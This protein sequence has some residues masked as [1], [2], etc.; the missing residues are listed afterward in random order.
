MLVKYTNEL[1]ALKPANPASKT[2]D[3]NRGKP[4]RQINRFQGK[5]QVQSWKAFR[6]PGFVECCVIVPAL[7]EKSGLGCSHPLPNESLG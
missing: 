5:K 2:R 1:F 6:A 7:Q 3:K 4:F